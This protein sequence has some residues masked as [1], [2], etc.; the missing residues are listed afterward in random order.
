MPKVILEGEPKLPM[1]VLVSAD[2]APAQT[3]N[4]FGHAFLLDLVVLYLTVALSY[5]T[6]PE[7]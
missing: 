7:A 6:Q 5:P 1:R 3:Q 2:L 4:Q